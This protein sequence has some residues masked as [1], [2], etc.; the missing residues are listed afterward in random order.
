MV[1]LVLLALVI[2]NILAV[3]ALLTAGDE[4]DASRAM[5][6]SS[7]AFY[8]A[9]AGLQKIFAEADSNVKV[10]LDGLAAGDSLDLGW[11]TL[12]GGMSYRGLIY[13]WDDDGPPQYE[14]VVEGRG[15][16]P[17]GGK[18]TLSFA[19]TSGPKSGY[20][21]GQC[22][23]AAATVRGIVDIN[24][25][26]SISGF[27]QHPP[28]WETTDACNAEGE[29][30]AGLI[31]Q[32]TT[33]LNREDSESII[34][35]DPSIIEDPTL[36]DSSFN[37]FNGLTWDSLKASA[38]FSIGTPGTATKLDPSQVYPRYTIDMTTGETICDTSHPLNWGSKDPNDPCFDHFPLIVTYGDLDLEGGMYGQAILLAD[39][40]TFVNEYGETITGGS[41]ID[42]EEGTELN[43]VILGRG[44]VEIQ[45][46]AVFH[47]GIFVDGNYWTGGYPGMGSLLCEPDAPLDVNRGSTAQY[48]QCAVDRAILAAGLEDFG[49]V[50]NKG[51][52]QLLKFHAFR[53]G[54]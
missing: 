54:M 39:T 46:N 18:R 25:A 4:F 29:D 23:D 24:D 37:W 49:Q 34:E 36:N 40:A 35:G 13:R 27:D 15:A 28:G 20:R 50:T 26:S 32:D 11:Q 14:L 33:L 6:E 16:G 3:G 48:S 21:L 44:C 53:E 51:G 8:A 12:A 42:I 45:E 43:G 19:M 22:C 9:E 10:Q 1:P 38:Q 5:Y 41:E 17:R 7:S 52:L 31:H 47:G 2:L 30:R